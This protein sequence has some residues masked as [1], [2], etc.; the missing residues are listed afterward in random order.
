[1]SRDP[2]RVTLTNLRLESDG[3]AL[4]FM[5]SDGYRAALVSTPGSGA[6]QLDGFQIDGAAAERIET[7]LE[8]H[9]SLVRP[10]G[11]GGA[12]PVPLVQVLAAPASGERAKMLVFR[13][14]L[15]TFA[16]AHVAAGFPPIRKAIPHAD[17][18]GGLAVVAARELVDAFAAIGRAKD[19][20][21]LEFRDGLQV[22]NQAKKG[23]PNLRFTVRDAFVSGPPRHFIMDPAL[24]GPALAAATS[25]ER[26]YIGL[27]FQSNDQFPPL[28][29]TRW[30]ASERPRDRREA[31]AKIHA[32]VRGQNL[33]VIMPRRE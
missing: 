28:V 25:D 13:S 29:I 12:R 21:V 30:P 11:R 5:A 2:A 10:R 4:T 1:M 24:M 17:A 3:D 27:A 31:L 9:L 26:A 18:L 33:A 6:R 32:E 14:E 22:T 8:Q 16:A 7:L 19:I 20:A 23:Q 15:F